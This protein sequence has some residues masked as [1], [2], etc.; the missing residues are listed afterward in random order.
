[1]SKQAIYTK[2]APDAVG[3]YSQAV[4]VGNLTI[5]YGQIPLDP[6]T[7]QLVEGGIEAQTER[8]LRNLEAVLAE[9]GLTFDDVIK[10][11]VFLA[12]I[13]DFAAMNE[14]YARFFS[15]PYPARSAVQVAALP[16]GARVEIECICGK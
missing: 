12:D 9:A 15:A 6:A 16:K 1:M 4:R 7:N 2:N 3:P 14:V 10:T 5:T 11:T 13:G 8:V